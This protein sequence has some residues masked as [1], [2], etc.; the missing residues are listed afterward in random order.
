MSGGV[1]RSSTRSDRRM[2][3]SLG[4]PLRVGLVPLVPPVSGPHTEYTVQPT[5]GVT[6]WD[7]SPQQVLHNSPPGE[8]RTPD[9]R[10]NPA[11]VFR[12]LPRRL[13]ATIAASFANCDGG[14][15]MSIRTR[16]S[17]RR[18]LQAGAA[19]AT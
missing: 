6:Q 2:G 1:R 11:P 9:D 18:F 12:G 14:P 16:I 10:T 7:S 3:H 5:P 15:P 4:E 19:L 8:A 17:R 13:C